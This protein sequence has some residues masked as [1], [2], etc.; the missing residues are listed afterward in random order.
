M[1]EM[2][3]TAARAVFGRGDALEPLLEAAPDS[4]GPVVVDDADRVAGDGDRETHLFHLFNLAAQPRRGLLLIGDEPPSAWPVGLDDLRSRL[5]AATVLKVAL[6]DDEMI[7][8]LLLKLFSDRQIPIDSGL[9][10]YAL[11]RMERSYDAARDLVERVD[12]LSLARKS[13]IN[14]QLVDLAIAAREG[15]KT[16]NS[17]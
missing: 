9:V 3:A 10:G 1:A 16:W 7:E 8:N 11:K 6:P 12:Q 17:D 4:R 2:W 5:R 15:D 14:N 13:R